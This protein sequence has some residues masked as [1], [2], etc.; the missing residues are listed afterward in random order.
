MKTSKGILGLE[1][2]STL[3]SMANLAST[4]QNQRRWKEAE[5]L[6][7]QVIDT[8]K[9]ILGLEHPSTLTSMVN[10]AF[11]LRSLSKNEIALEM[12]AKYAKSN[13]RI[14][15]PNHPNTLSSMSTYKEWQSLDKTL[16]FESTESQII[17]SLEEKTEATTRASHISGISQRQ[18][19]I[20]LLTLA[21]G[22][23][24]VLT[25]GYKTYLD[26]LVE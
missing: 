22:F 9:G 1:H 17:T 8:R 11:T 26:G 10:L 15:G 23:I 18:I 12:M 24:Y 16:S 2:P 19:L 5:D 20:S 13:S 6:Q 25:K 7:L 14:L 3:T 21:L 4:Y